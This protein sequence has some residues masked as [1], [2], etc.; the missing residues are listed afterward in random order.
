MSLV[1][2]SEMCREDGQGASTDSIANRAV[3]LEFGGREIRD[4]AVILCVLGVAEQNDAFDLGRDSGAEIL[5]R[6]SYDSGT[7]AIKFVS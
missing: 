3:N 6:A 4:T 1:D 5:N 2:I 7:L